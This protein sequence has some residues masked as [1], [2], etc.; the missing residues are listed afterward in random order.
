MSKKTL[1]VVDAPGPAEFIAPALPFLKNQKD[2]DFSI[3]TVNNSSSQ[4]LKEYNSRLCSNE[5]EA[6]I[7]Y[8]EIKPDILV[9][10]MS[11]LANGPFV[12]SAFTKLTHQDDKKIICFQDFWANHRWPMNFKMMSY[13]DAVLVIDELAKM[14]LLEDQYS[15]EM[16]ITGNPGFD[17]FKNV[18]VAAKR[19]ELRQKFNLA[20]NEKVIF[21]IGQGTPTTWQ[22]DEITFK[23][24]TE[25]LQQ[26][27]AKNA[28][29]SPLVLMAHPHPRDENPDRYQKLA[30]SLKFYNTSAMA[31]ADELLPLADVV[32]SMYSTNSIHACYLRI[33][34]VSILLPDAGQARLK[35]MR[36][37]D[38]PPNKY[39]ASV[40]VYSQSIEELSSVLEKVLFDADYKAAIK[41]AQEKNFPIDI[42]AAPLAAEAIIKLAAN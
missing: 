3:V 7:L 42:K 27:Q 38:F 24:L 6:E 39:G 29:N 25:T 18:N 12:N 36:L 22:A 37:D 8:Q 15:G 16:V 20:E 30:G 34:T 5:A 26:C 10:A 21:Y 31:L 1:I 40:G 33:P 41:T 11:S 35:I 28:F 19:A 2:F 32:A 14:F 9:V 17:K 4:V 13:W 23:F